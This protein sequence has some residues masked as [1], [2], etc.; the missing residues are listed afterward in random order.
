[1]P[2]DEKVEVAEVEEDLDK[3]EDEEKVDSV[4]E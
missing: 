2:E 1:M 4:D 3:N